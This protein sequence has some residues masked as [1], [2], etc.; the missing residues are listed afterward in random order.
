MSIAD[1]ANAESGASVRSKLNS[2]IAAVN[3]GRETLTADR[4]YFVRTDGSDS[5]DGLA[6]TS[7]GAFLTWARAFSTIAAIDGGG[8]IVTVQGNGTFTAN[9]T[10]NQNFVGVTKIIISG[11]TA[12]PANCTFGATSGVACFTVDTLTP[13]DFTGV[14]LGNGTGPTNGLFVSRGVA[15]IT[16]NCHF[17]A[18]TTHQILLQGPYAVLRLR[19]NYS[20]VGGAA[21][22]CAAFDDAFLDGDS[23]SNYTVT[24]TGSPS[25]S[26]AFYVIGRRG[27]ML[28]VNVIYSGGISGGAQQLNVGALCQ[29]LVIRAGGS[30]PIPGTNSTVNSLA[31]SSVT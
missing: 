11:D 4:T 8:F 20:V 1:I 26:T 17:G 31:S 10:I 3:S 29:L 9:V 28:L 2:V 14:R 15:S 5:N 24:V 6:N 16:G 18:V 30:G 22:H 12:T 7:G 13:V 23:T 25:F 27:G 19:A 21:V